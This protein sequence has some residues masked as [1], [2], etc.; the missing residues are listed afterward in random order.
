MGQCIRIFSWC[1]PDQPIC[2][3][4]HAK[5]R[6]SNTQTTISTT[7]R[8]LSLFFIATRGLSKDSFMRERGGYKKSALPADF[9]YIYQLVN[10][11]FTIRIF[12]RKDLVNFFE[13]FGEVPWII[14]AD[15]IGNLRN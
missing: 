3:P 11:S 10:V 12:R 5:K 2:T 1:Q 13:I 6:V 9:V 7:S 15:P 4:N 14:K 8:A